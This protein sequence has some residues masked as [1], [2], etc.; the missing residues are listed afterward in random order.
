M[1]E[2]LLVKW[3]IIAQEPPRPMLH[4]RRCGGT[5]SFRSG[6]KVR[7]N[8][9]GKRVDAWLVYRC[10]SCDGTWN[11]P[12]LERRLV[13][14]ID[15]SLLASLTANDPDVVAAIA[16]DTGDLRRGTPEIEE[17]ANVAVK[18]QV[19]SGSMAQPRAL[20]IHCCVPFPVTLR[21]DRLLA[22]ELQLSRSRIHALAGS[23]ALAVA[24][25][26]TSRALRKPVRD[27]MEVTIRLP[28]PDAAWITR[29]AAAGDDAR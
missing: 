20:R 5:R 9:N 2:I 7:V 29:L 3:T 6:G 28:V 1:S 8:A 26:N 11:R 24:G 15:P 22:D 13:Q 17:A 4:C 16:L 14:S 23:G 12:I 21:L 10:T 27:G 18:K 25:S 19:L